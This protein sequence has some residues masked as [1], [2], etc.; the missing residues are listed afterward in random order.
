MTARLPVPGSDNGTWG[1]VLNTYLEVAH[2]A[3]GNVIGLIPA[4][5][6]VAA[7]RALTSTTAPQYVNL[8]SYYAAATV[9]AD[10]GGGLLQ[11]VSSDTSTAD[12][13]ITVFVD[14]ASRR[15]YRVLNG[16][17][18][19][20]LQAGCVNDGTTDSSTQLN[21]ALALAVPVM[22][23]ANTHIAAA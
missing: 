1:D 17:T 13:G 9:A 4:I 23:P 14:A 5:A 6:N 18:L 10:G 19:T 22:I 20:V 12:N 8:I 11:Y 7:L 16:A 15:W 21:A 2:D 3:A